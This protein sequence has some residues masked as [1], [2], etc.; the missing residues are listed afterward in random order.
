[1]F[2]TG[3]RSRQ[4]SEVRQGAKDQREC[5]FKLQRRAGRL[6]SR[7]VLA[8]QV[9]GSVILQSCGGFAPSHWFAAGLLSVAH[10]QLWVHMV[11]LVGLILLKRHT[12]S[13]LNSH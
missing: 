9:R 12:E 3:N 6:G 7:L 10:W 1:M 5:L 4:L 13:L 2:Q 11:D 8:F